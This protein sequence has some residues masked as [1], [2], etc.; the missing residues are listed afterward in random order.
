MGTQEPGMSIALEREGYADKLPNG[1]CRAYWDADGGVWTIGHG[2]TGPDVVK[3]LIWTAEKAYAR[4]LADWERHKQGV[5]RAS[6][7]LRALPN[8]LGACTSFAYNVGVGRYQSSTL[9]RYVNQERWQEAADEFPKWNLAGGRKLAGLVTRRALERKLF[10]TPDDSLPVARNGAP[11]QAAESYS[12]PQSWPGAIPS[13]L[14]SGVPTVSVLEGPIS[15]PIVP[16]SEHYHEDYAHSQSELTSWP[17]HL[18][19]WLRSLFAGR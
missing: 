14:T 11:D 4:F 8:K 5:L 10:L 3:G 19:V 13:P 16:V 9:R 15:T 12:A 7:V 1:D 6:P 17:M 2:S 18:P